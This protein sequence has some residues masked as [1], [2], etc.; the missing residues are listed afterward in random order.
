MNRF[1]KVLGYSTIFLAPL[2][3][4]TLKFFLFNLSLFRSALLAWFGV[5]LFTLIVSNKI[6]IDRLGAVFIVGTLFSSVVSFISSDNLAS[7]TSFLFNEIMGTMILF[8]FSQNYSHRDVDDLLKTFLLS[9]LIPV[10]FSIW[11]IYSFVG[12]G[13]IISSL[14]MPRLLSSILMPYELQ[15]TDLGGIPRLWMPFSVG[16]HMAYFVLVIVVLLVYENGTIIKNRVLK[17][18]ALG[19]SGVM[20]IGTFSRMA[21]L[22][23]SLVIIRNAIYRKGDYR[24]LVGVLT[25]S[26][27]LAFLMPLILPSYWMDLQRLF[28]RK[29]SFDILQDRHVLLVYEGIYQWLHSFRTILVGVGMNNNSTLV[30]KYTFLPP[31][32]SFLSNYV[33]LL[34]ERGLLGVLTIIVPIFIL[35][36]R[37]DRCAKKLKDY[38]NRNMYL[39]LLMSWI[40]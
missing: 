7:S 38:T 20:L 16:P 21:L 1:N 25:F 31:G 35:K 23:L 33:T 27:L 28:S 24:N 34:V 14:P 37:V 13:E 12:N 26:M 29:L 15:S 18:S 17:I 4:Y 9:A 39:A 36:K 30:T 2:D 19:I 5:T 10:I 11:A 32:S 40:Y 6:K 3:T 8:C 22:S